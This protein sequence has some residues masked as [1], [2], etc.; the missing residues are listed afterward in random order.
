M[1][2]TR[3]IKPDARFFGLFVGRSGSGKSVAAYSFPE[4]IKVFDMDGRVRGGIAVPWNRN[5]NIDYTY[6]PPWVPGKAKDETGNLSTFQKLNNDFESLLMDAQ[7]GMS[8]YNTVV[9][10][11][12]T[13][14]TIDMLLD[15]IPLT[16]V[17]DKGKRLGSLSM[18]GPEDYGFQ[19]TATYQ[20][21]AFLKSLPIQNI[22][23]TAHIVNKW[24]KPGGDNK[25]AENVIIGEQLSLTDKLA[26]N[27]PSSFDH[28]FKFM[29]Y[30]SGSSVN[31]KFAAQGELARSAYTIPYGEHDITNKDFYTNMAQWAPKKIEA[32][33]K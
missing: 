18:A 1:P 25:Y 5:R 24:G 15:A 33:A 6:Y 20:I 21:I 11:S 7:I 10:D 16:H 17:K 12:I 9:L 27:I 2:N 32:V 8:K 23:V 26:E 28:V 31:Y 29:K 22:I 4:P 19:A 14:E 3:D 30:D 13:W